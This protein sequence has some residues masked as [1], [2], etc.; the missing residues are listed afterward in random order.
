MTVEYVQIRVAFGRPIG[1]FE[2]VQARIADMAT[3]VQ[4]ARFLVYELLYQ[5]DVEEVDP[6][7]VASV[8]GVAARTV[9]EA[10]NWGH[11]LHGGVGF[12]AEYDLQFH[13]RRG[14]EAALRWGDPREVTNIV[15]EAVLA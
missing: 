7:Q 10:T 11:I 14:K 13:T 3:F 5:F 15:A 9:T 4:A 12:M 1:T 6:V 2:V 8:K